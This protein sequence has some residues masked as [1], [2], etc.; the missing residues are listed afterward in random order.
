MF[1]KLVFVRNSAKDVEFFER[2]G[3]VHEIFNSRILN[4][5]DQ[6]INRSVEYNS[7]DDVEEVAL[8]LG[9]NKFNIYTF[10]DKNAD[11]FLE[12]KGTFRDTYRLR[13]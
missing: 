6:I 3:E 7:M 5:F 13:D 12:S 1:V 8:R 10:F 9:Y 4:F 11:F 2:K